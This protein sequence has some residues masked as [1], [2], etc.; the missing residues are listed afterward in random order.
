MSERPLL[1]RRV[2]LADSSG[3]RMEEVQGRSKNPG[4]SGGP[5]LVIRDVSG[6]DATVVVVGSGGQVLVADV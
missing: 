2:M 3:E 5:S 1:V 6:V 4:R